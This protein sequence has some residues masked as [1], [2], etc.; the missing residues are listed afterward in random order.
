PARAPVHTYAIDSAVVCAPFPALLLGE[1]YIFLPQVRMFADIIIYVSVRCGAELRSPVILAVPVRLG[2]VD[3][4]TQALSAEFP[5]ESA[6]DVSVLMCMEGTALCCDL[7]VCCI[8]V[9][10]TES[11]MMLCCKKQVF[12][13]AVRG[14]RRLS[15][16][17]EFYGI[18]SPVC[19]PVLLLAGLDVGPC[20][21]FLAP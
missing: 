12:K 4:D 5:E 10:H 18:E 11:V 15:D 21:I 16:G 13:P 7:I 6:D 1:L 2:K 8:R 9:I 17:I 14:E 19:I 3:G 20:H